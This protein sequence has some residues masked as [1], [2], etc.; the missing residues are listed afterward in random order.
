MDM[1]TQTAQNLVRGQE[2]R[3][4]TPLLETQS[5]RDG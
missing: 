5:R 2:K 3:V 1:T 4:K